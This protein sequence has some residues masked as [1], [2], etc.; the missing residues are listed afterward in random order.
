LLVDA[1]LT[2]NVILI[3]GTTND[4]GTPRKITASSR[5]LS[6]A[7][8]VFK[9]MLSPR[10]KE[11]AAL[12]TA[13]S[14]ELVLEDDNPTVMAAICDL[15][16]HR[17]DTRQANLL[18][19]HSKLIADFAGLC[20]KYDLVAKMRPVV[21]VWI[22][23]NAPPDLSYRSHQRMQLVALA[24]VFELKLVLAGMSTDLIAHYHGRTDH[25][26]PDGEFDNPEWMLGKFSLDDCTL[27][28]WELLEAEGLT[29]IM[30]SC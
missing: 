7:S 11:G 3:C 29:T 12:A 19:K 1:I 21:S 26:E 5:I 30:Q 28:H 25:W 22:E 10:F 13:G 2:D 23:D 8:P 9:A 6:A 14:L 27:V 16:H 15:L 18:K 24:D 20:D 4:G 17:C